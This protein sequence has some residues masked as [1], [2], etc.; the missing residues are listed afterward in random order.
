MKRPIQRPCLHL[1]QLFRRALNMFRDRMAM[2][3][4]RKKCTQNQQVK[5]ALQ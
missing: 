3:R 4:P 2:R 5:R 1:Q